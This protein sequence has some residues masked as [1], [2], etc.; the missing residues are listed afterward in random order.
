MLT[1][2]I[3][4]EMEIYYTTQQNINPYV[5]VLVADVSDGLAFN[6]KIVFPTQ[7]NTLYPDEPE[8]I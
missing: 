1:A 3:E 4:R 7:N 6:N 2:V 5:C 8:Y